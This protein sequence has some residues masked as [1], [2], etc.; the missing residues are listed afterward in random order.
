MNVTQVSARSESFTESVI[1][2]MTRLISCC[3]IRWTA[4]IWRRGFPISPRRK[5][6]RTPPAPRSRT[7]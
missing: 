5:S 7:T 3:T 2:E 6:S 1:R 4:S